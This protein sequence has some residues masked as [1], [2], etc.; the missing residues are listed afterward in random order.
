M[1]ESRLFRVLYHLLENGRATAPEL[2]EKL[3]VS[4]R[5]IY[6]DVDRLSQAGIPL[7]CSQGKGGGIFLMEDFVLDKHLLTASERKDLLASLQGVQVLSQSGM[8]LL[9][10]LQGLFQLKAEPWLQLDF[11]SWQG[12]KDLN[13]IYDLLKRAILQKR[14]L[15]FTYPNPQGQPVDRQAEPLQ[16]IFK[17]Q[18]WYLAAFCRLRSAIRFFKISRMRQIQVSEERFF[19]EVPSADLRLPELT[20]EL[21]K[22]RLKFDRKAAFRVLEEFPDEAVEEAEGFLYVECLLPRHEHLYSYLLSFLDSVEIIEPAE[23]R[24]NFQERLRRIAEKYKT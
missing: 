9:D 1:A 7:Y 3:E 8:D 24:R 17:N 18:D 5:T 20:E 13:K 2:A 10:K 23:L 21:V 22:I 4:V 11:S 15:L 14:V 12:Q 16:L 6:R 19:R